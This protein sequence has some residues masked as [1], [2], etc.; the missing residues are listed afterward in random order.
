V[1]WAGDALRPGLP[2]ADLALWR[3]LSEPAGL[4]AFLAHPDFYSREMNVVAVGRV[5]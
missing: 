5:T 1:W 4:A 2:A 3:E